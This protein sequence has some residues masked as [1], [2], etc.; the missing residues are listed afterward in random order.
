MKKIGLALGGGGARGLSH[1]AFVE[2]LDEV[3]LKPAIISGT[4]IGAIVGA[5]YAAG[6]TASQMRHILDTVKFRDINKMIDFSIRKNS[7]MLKGAGVENFFHKHIP[8]RFFNELN[9]PLKIVATDFWNRKEVIF[10]SGDLIF[11]IRASMSLPF[12]FKPVQLGDMILV[13]GGMVNPLP[14]DIIRDQCDI[15]IAIDVSG[16]KTPSLR[17]STPRMFESVLSSFQIMQASIVQNKMKLFQPDIYIKPSLQNIR[18]LNFDKHE[19]IINSVKD[20]VIYLQQELDR[21]LTKNRFFSLFG[22]EN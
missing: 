5:F 17:R 9:I 7:A 10:E 6:L 15:V 22:R 18:T 13:D 11:A 2:A 12:I 4:S 19:D 1:I 21:M 20:D 16:E 14:Y 8:A 3:G